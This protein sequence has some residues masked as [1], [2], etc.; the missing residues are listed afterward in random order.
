MNA[1]AATDAQMTH[2]SFNTNVI[3]IAQDDLKMFLERLCEGSE[4]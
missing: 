1:K 3:E 2:I 4:A